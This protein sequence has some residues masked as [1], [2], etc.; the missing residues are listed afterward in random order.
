MTQNQIEGQ[1]EVQGSLAFQSERYH[2]MDNIRALAMLGGVL[3]HCAL[4]YGVLVQEL[5]PVVDPKRSWWVDAFL[6]FSHCFRMPLF[7]IV[8]GFFAHLLMQRYGPKR[9]LSNRLKRL[10][11]PF[12]VFWP[13]V[14]FMTI[15]AIGCIAYFTS[16]SSP[17]LDMIRLSIQGKEAAPAQQGISTMHF[18][19]LYY[20][21][22][23][24][25]LAFL[26]HLALLKLQAL[27][28]RS[29]L[30]SAFVAGSKKAL[31]N[32]R[33]Q[34]LI[35]L[36]V[37]PLLLALFRIKQVVPFQPPYGLTIELWAIGYFGA[38]Y[39]LGWVLYAQKT[40]LYLF[41]RPACLL[42]VAALI[43]YFPF[44]SLLPEPYLFE[45]SLKSGFSTVT[46]TWQQF[47]LVLCSALIACY[48]SYA[49]LVLAKRFLD[50]S[51]SLMRYW[52]DASYWIYLVHIPLLYPINAYLA[53]FDIPLIL[54]LVVS[55]TM[56]M[57]FSLGF[58]ALMVRRSF[59]G[60][61]L[62]GKR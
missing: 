18:W 5:W 49:C 39:A 50:T 12:I 33:V 15:V 43:L 6:W 61:L 26:F 17:L 14:A 34:L 20:L 22:I 32:D 29:T 21:V 54:K 35:L 52:S 13:L 58:Y 23:F 16:L 8:A 28:A 48:M 59:I 31:A 42:V 10:A 36:I 1:D 40:L 25:V 27:T 11:L 38:F 55:V 62:N 46:I 9:F 57:V 37:F 56:V 53:G 47:I 7:F 51:N 3:F 30:A 2:Y 19:F 24:S 60:A 41:E 45:T 44:F 4:S